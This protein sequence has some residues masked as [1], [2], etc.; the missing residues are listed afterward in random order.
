MAIQRMD[1]VGIVVD[2]LPAAIAFFLEL[3]LELEGEASVGGPGVDRLVGLDG[4]QAD[5]A[6]VRTPDGHGRLEL[7]K[8]HT[9]PATTAEPNAPVNTFGIRR[10]MFAVEDIEDVIARLRAH[11]AELV[12][13]L[14]QYEDSY[15]LCYVRGPGGILVALAEELG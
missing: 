10:I 9:P 2:D 15:R 7:T 11:G 4:V 13:E 8:F 5:L 3:G 12:G 6:V 14:E 1:N